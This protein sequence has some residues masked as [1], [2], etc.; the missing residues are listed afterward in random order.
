MILDRITDWI[1]TAW[2]FIG[3]LF[4]SAGA[5]STVLDRWEAGR[6]S[7]RDRPSSRPSAPTAHSIQHVHFA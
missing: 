3:L 5:D 4:L 6:D 7:E 2:E 1:V